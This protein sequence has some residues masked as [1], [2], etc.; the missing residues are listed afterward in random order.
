MVKIPGPGGSGTVEMGLPLARIV[1]VNF[2]EPAEFAAAQAA[3][4]KGD[5]AKV[6]T[7]TATFVKG[8]ADFK[9]LPGSWWFKMA[10]LRLYALASAGRDVECC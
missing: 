6:L 1:K 10:R 9:D 5:A 2:A 4:M 7:L 3:E 8:Q